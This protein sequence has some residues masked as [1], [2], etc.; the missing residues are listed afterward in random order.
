MPRGH[1]TALRVP[2]RV[3]IT[4]N[5]AKSAPVWVSFI[6]YAEFSGVRI[7]NVSNVEPTSQQLGAIATEYKGLLVSLL[8][9]PKTHNLSSLSELTRKD[10]ESCLTSPQWRCSSCCYKSG[11]CIDLQSFGGLSNQLL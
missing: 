3:A 8:A 7:P 9:G 1:P 10:K 4:D 6:S 5:I 11:L 2:A